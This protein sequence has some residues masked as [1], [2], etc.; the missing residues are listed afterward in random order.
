[1]NYSQFS[2][3]DFVTDPFFQQWIQRPDPESD[4]FWESWLAA[5]PD[6][7]PEVEEARRI[8]A[9]FSEPKP[10]FSPTE[11]DQLWQDIDK[12]IPLP[13]IAPDPASNRSWWWGWRGVA[14]VLALLILSAFVIYT[15][16]QQYGMVRYQTAYGEHQVVR[17]PDGSVVYLNANSSLRTPRSWQADQPRRIWLEGE[18]FFEVTHKQN[19]QLFQVITGEVTVS[20]RGTT[21]NVWE[22]GGRAKVVLNTGK[23]EVKTGNDRTVVMQPGE[24]VEVES[25]RLKV[26]ARKVDPALYSAWK[27]RQLVFRETPLRDIVALLKDNYGLEVK[28]EDQALLNKKITTQVIQENVDLLLQLLAESLEVEVRRDQHQVWFRKPAYAPSSP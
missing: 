21:F 11:L 2:V 14:A 28:V 22:R 9:A 13:E 24:M 27:E 3:R 18:A 23:V 20:V 1:M 4:S 6:K 17:L 8:V 16:Q 7:A 25:A 19:H 15:Y 5:H 12:R 26:E 10:A